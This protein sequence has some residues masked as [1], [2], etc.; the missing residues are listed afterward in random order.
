MPSHWSPY[1]LGQAEAS[2]W[3]NSDPEKPRMV[4]PPSMKMLFGCF[5]RV[6]DLKKEA[7]I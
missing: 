5:T 7:L 3:V 4:T 2:G 6:T 1:S